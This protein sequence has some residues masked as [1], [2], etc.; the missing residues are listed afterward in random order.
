LLDK[1]KSEQN[2]SHLHILL[3]IVPTGSG[4][5]APAGCNHS[6]LTT[7]KLSLSQNKTGCNLSCLTTTKLSYKSEQNRSHLHILLLIVRTGSGAAAPAGCNLS[8][9]TSLNQ[10]KT[11]HTCTSCCSLFPLAAVLPCRLAA[12]LIA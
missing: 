1:F 4:A 7:T 12:I 6:R 2:R 11:V 5:A 3:L 8:C 9:L 10:N